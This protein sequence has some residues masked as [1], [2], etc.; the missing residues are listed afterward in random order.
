MR[1]LIAIGVLALATPAIAQDMSAF[2]TG[3]VFEEYGPTAPVDTDMEI[4]A[5]ATFNVAFDTAK[6][7]DA[8][9]LNRT[10][11]SAARFVNMHA[12]A[13]IPLENIKV[14]VVVHGKASE[15]LLGPEEYTKRRE[16]AENANIALIAALTGHN[17]RVILC[18][19]SAAA[20]GIT[21]DMLAPGVEMARSAMTAHALLQQEGYTV[22][23]F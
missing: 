11:E 9:K 14:A 21:N 2:T 1:S 16:G 12:K 23:P 19:Q 5:D 13:G 17:V 4:P 7:A 20:Y 15:D 10:L 22:N 8:G 18:G 3:P 6:G